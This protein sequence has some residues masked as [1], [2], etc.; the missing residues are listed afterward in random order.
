MDIEIF[1]F[2]FAVTC[3]SYQHLYFPFIVSNLTHEDCVITCVEI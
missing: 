1:S 2:L 3:T